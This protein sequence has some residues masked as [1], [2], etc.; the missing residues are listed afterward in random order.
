MATARAM[1]YTEA[2]MSA[3]AEEMLRRHRPDTVDFQDNYDGRHRDPV[4]LPVSAPELLLNGSS[5]IAVAWPPNIPPH[6]LNELCDAV[7]NADRQL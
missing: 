5:G 7:I 4:I 1:R 2:R 6:N 3:I